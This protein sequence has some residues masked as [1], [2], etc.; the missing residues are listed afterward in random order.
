MF[1]LVISIIVLIGISDAAFPL[2]ESLPDSAFSSNS[3]YNDN[4]NPHPYCVDENARRTSLHGWCA[5]TVD[6][7]LQSAYIQVDLGG[8]YEI[9]SIST[10]PR[11]D[12][13]SQY[14]KTYILSYS[15]DGINWTDYNDGEI[16]NGNQASGT[17]NDIV[18]EVNNLLDPPIYVASHLRITP[19][20]R[21][22]WMSG[23]IEAY[24]GI[25]IYIYIFNRK[26][27][28]FIFNIYI[29]I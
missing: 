19:Q 28:F 23:R 12:S 7:D 21:G 17:Q 11:W 1:N 8:E 25:F 5:R 9:E 24:G 18:D 29:Y 16:L 15:L 2:I 10:W 20:S 13:Q 3:Q 26:I 22:T 27:A 14:I 4:D 6:I